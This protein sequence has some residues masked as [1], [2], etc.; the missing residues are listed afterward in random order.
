MS[1]TFRTCDNTTLL[2]QVGRMNV[3]AISGGRVTSRD[4]GVTLPVGAGYVVTIDLDGNDT[5][6]VRRVFRRAG[7]EW[8]KGEQ[9]N[10]YCDEVGEVAYRASC[11]RNGPWGVS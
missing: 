10:V 3:L 5:Y 6:V 2:K 9:R 11:F 4:T 1:D 8:V 7:R